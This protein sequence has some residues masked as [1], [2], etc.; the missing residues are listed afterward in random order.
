MLGRPVDVVDYGPLT[1]LEVDTGGCYSTVSSSPNS[2]P[3]TEPPTGTC[4]HHRQPVG[5]ARVWITQDHP[6]ILRFEQHGLNHVHNVLD[7]SIHF[8]FQVTAL[9][10]GHGPSAQALAYRPPVAPALRSISRLQVPPVNTLQD[11]T[12]VSA[13][14]FL[15]VATPVAFPLSLY[16]RLATTFYGS[17]PS[18]PKRFGPPP[19][20]YIPGMDVLFSHVRRWVPIYTSWHGQVTIYV[21]GPYLLVQ[22]RRL[23]GGLPANFMRGAATTA[24][25]CR[26]W[27]GTYWDGQRWLAFQRSGIAVIISSNSLGDSDLLSYAATVFC[28]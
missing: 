11:P 12:D 20:P 24:G 6:F 4:I 22:E 5:W 17:E 28:H 16:S 15:H 10:F 27:I 2:T 3:V 18:A 14:D 21:T 8:R 1:V 23:A 26:V 7:E 19:L 9:S 13:P 25:V